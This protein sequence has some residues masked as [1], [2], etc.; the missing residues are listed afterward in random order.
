MSYGNIR[1][2]IDGNYFI[3]SCYSKIQFNTAWLCFN[4]PVSRS[5]E[6][7]IKVLGGVLCDL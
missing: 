7:P 1:M 2:E 5:L 3:M 6:L 4:A